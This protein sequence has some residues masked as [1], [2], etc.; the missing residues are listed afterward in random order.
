MRTRNALLF[1]LALFAAA[2]NA[3]TARPPQPQVTMGADIKLLRFDWEPVEGASYYHLR[4]RPTVGAAYQPLGARI[5]ATVTQ[6]ETG[7]PVH[8]QDWS[9]MRFAVAACNAAGCTRSAALDPRPLM[10]DTIGY[11]K[12]SNS[13][14][15]D[16]FGQSVALSADGFT[17]AVGSAFEDSNATGVNGDQANNDVR[18]SG[19]VY[20]FRRRGN[21]WH[22]S[23]YLKA[24]ISQPS[25]GF[26]VAFEFDFAGTALSA[27]GSIL[28]VTAP[29]ETV[30]GI[31]GA[32]AVYVFRRSNNVPR[33][34]TT[35]S[36][37]R[38]MA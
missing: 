9:G 8:L 12:S 29:R 20:V 10:L 21:T 25:H 16:Y 38:P 24:G 28:A 35:P 31:R 34:R 26:G 7:L 37:M 36:V 22:Q 23:S 17:L 30:N 2:A 33:S 13:E 14:R 5:P 18:D 4:F 6:T 11:L 15:F 32:G 3:Q 27:D 19:A 1:A